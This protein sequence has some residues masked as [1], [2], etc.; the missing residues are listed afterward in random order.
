MRG[1]WLCGAALLALAACGRGGERQVV[2]GNVA[3]SGAPGD[4]TISTPNGSAQIHSGAGA[5]LANSPEGIPAYPNQVAGQSIDLNG[6]SA[7]GQGHILSFATHD[8]PAQ[9]IAFYAQAVAAAGY[10][11]A[12]RLDMG[13][14]SELTAQRGQGQ[15]IQ[16]VAT[17]AGD[18]TRVQVT[19]VTR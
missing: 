17:P 6:G 1:R 4:I 2:A 9:V 12:N 3:M 13:P 11:V 18:A 8:A 5:G 15:A 14:A 7:P 19:F 16:I 10:T